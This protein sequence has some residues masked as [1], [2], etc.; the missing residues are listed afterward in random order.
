MIRT[1][2]GGG[3]PGRPPPPSGYPRAVARLEALPGTLDEQPG[4]Q[5]LVHLVT[6]RETGV[7]PVPPG[8]R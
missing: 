2:G 8:D 6:Q 4:E 1:G 7:V 3:P 5:V